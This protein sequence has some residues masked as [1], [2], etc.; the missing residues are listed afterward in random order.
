MPGE[1]GSAVETLVS[2][3]RRQDD[4][5]KVTLKN[6]KALAELA[7]KWDIPMLSYDIDVFSFIWSTD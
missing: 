5:G 3:L 4:K 6:Y 1:N 2:W 7:D